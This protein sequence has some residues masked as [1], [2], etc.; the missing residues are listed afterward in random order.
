L[1]CT[2]E[3]SISEQREVLGYTSSR[4]ELQVD[5][6]CKTQYYRLRI[7]APIAM[8]IL[9][10]WVTFFLRDYRKRIDIAGGNL[11][12][13]IA[14]NFIISGDLPRLSYLTYH[15]YRAV[16]RLLRGLSG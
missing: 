14:F 1:P 4:F 15:G 11:L 13:F 16:Y 3:T 10:S 6:T 5:A 9:I 8:I 12:I 2:F 7:L